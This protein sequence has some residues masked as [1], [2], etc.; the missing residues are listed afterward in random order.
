MEILEEMEFVRFVF[1]SLLYKEA[2]CSLF[3]ILSVQL[4]SEMANVKLV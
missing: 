3:I 1:H 4:T 2:L